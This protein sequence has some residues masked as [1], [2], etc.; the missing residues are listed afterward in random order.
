[1]ADYA[2]GKKG[3]KAGNFWPFSRVHRLGETPI[4]RGSGETLCDHGG[5][6]VR[7]RPCAFRGSTWAPERAHLANQT[8]PGVSRDARFDFSFQLPL[9]EH[10][11]KILPPERFGLVHAIFAFGFAFAATAQSQSDAQFA[12]TPAL[13]LVKATPANAESK[14]YFAWRKTWCLNGENA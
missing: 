5:A 12:A 7:T 3:K 2:R 13:P 1:M 4:H 14:Q 9:P 11:V 6:V 10:V 8:R